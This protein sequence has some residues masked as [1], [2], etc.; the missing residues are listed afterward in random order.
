MKAITAIFCLLLMGLGSTSEAQNVYNQFFEMQ[1]GNLGDYL[2]TIPT[3]VVQQ[4]NKI[5]GQTVIE[6]Y[7]QGTGRFLGFRGDTEEFDIRKLPYLK[8]KSV[9]KLLKQYEPG[10][11]VAILQETVI[12]NMTSDEVQAA[13]GEPNKIEDNEEGILWRYDQGIITLENGRVAII[14][15]FEED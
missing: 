5:E 10:V 6:I 11:A 15:L 1:E 9:K 2:N 8:R 12:H 14:E 4:R 3:R 13:W 7:E